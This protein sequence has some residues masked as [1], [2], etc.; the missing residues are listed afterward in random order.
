MTV[1]FLPDYTDTNPYQSN[2]RAELEALG[3]RVVL[4]RDRVF[5]PILGPVI[6]RDGVTVV[7][8][9]W[10]DAYLLSDSLPK[11]LLRALSMLF[12]LLVVRLLG[13]SVVWTCHNVRSHET[14]YPRVEYVFKRIVVGT[15]LCNH[16]FVH[17]EATKDELVAT[18]DLRKTAKSRMTVV[19]HGHYIDNYEDAVDRA[20][21]QR[22]LGVEEAETVFLFFGLIRPYK[23]VVSLVRTFKQVARPGDRLVVAGKPCEETIARRVSEEATSDERI[24]TYL[25]FIPTDRIQVYMNAADAV[26]LPLEDID[27]SGSAV[28]ARSFG[29]ALVLPR[30]GCMPEVIGEKGAVLYD[31]DAPDGLRGALESAQERDLESMGAYNR[32][33][34]NRR[35]W[36][37]AAERT[38]EVYR[39]RDESA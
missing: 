22:R 19:P 36:T 6:D 14:R 2:L 7:H 24:L 1:V 15:S 33:Q 12:E 17:C 11:T 39:A 23:N 9:H 3:E 4:A 34:A 10:F 8:V 37:E 28:L 13:V 29:A 25:E 27:M 18:Y 21:A 38:V 35:G 16:V 30:A 5:F 32:C 31:T 26:V 20:T